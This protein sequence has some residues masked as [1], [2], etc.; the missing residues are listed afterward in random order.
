MP[1]REVSRP[2][3]Q[4]I[5]VVEGNKEAI[6]MGAFDTETQIEGAELD[7]QEGRVLQSDGPASASRS[8]L[9][10]ADRVTIYSRGQCIKGASKPLER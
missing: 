4:T 2:R 9:S 6:R 8:V 5:S 7:C 10:V 1:I 3:A